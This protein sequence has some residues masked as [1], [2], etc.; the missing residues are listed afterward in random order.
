MPGES[1]AWRLAGFSAGLLTLALAT[2]SPFDQLTGMLLS[3]HMAQ[4]TLL[5]VLIPVLFVAGRSGDLLLAGMPDSWQQVLVERWGRGRE[6]SPLAGYVAEALRR[7]LVVGLIDVGALLIWH[8]PG[9]Y[10]AAVRNGP[11]HAL[12]LSSFLFAGLLSWRLVREPSNGGLRGYVATLVFLLGTSLIGMAFGFI[13]FNSST[14]WYPIYQGRTSL[15]DLRP[16]L[17][18]QIAGITLGVAPESFDVIPFMLVVAALL[19][20]EEALDTPDPSA[21]YSP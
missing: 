3:A 20:A 2:I 7:P 5:T 10:Q 19:R 17:D 14:L 15:W 18:Q 4:Y 11:L 9:I 16:I 12:E 6:R 21:P 13:L 1:R 8:E